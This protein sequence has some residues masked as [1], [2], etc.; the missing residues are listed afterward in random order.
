MRLEFENEQESKNSELISL[1]LGSDVQPSIGSVKD[2]IRE[3]DS[4][5]NGK[6]E[7]FECSYNG[8]CIEAYKHQEII[9]ELFPDDDNPLTC[10]IETIELRK[11]ILTWYRAVVIYQNKQGVIEEKEEV[12]DWIEEKQKI[13]EGLEKNL[14]R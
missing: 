13:G 12:L 7:K 11:L 10:Q 14:K 9:E 3:L 6:K 1:F 2:T 8:S 4:V 5:F